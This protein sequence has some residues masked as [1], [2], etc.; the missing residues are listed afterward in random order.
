[1]ILKIKKGM[2]PKSK[3]WD[4]SKQ[5]I[6]FTFKDGEF[7]TDDEYIIKFWGVDSSSIRPTE[8]IGAG[9]KPTKRKRRTKKT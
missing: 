1:M 5:K 9:E 2:S 8:N 3:I 7:D 6:L 4:D